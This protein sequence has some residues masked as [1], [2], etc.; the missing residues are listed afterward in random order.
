MRYCEATKKFWK[1]GYR[2]FGER[3]IRFM[4]RFK[5]TNQ[6]V[7]SETSRG[8]YDTQISDIN[9]A[10]KL[11]RDFQ[12]YDIELDKFESEP[13]IL[14]D[15]VEKMAKVMEGK[16]CCITFDG[17]KLKPG[18]TKSGGDVDL[19][20]FDNGPTLLEKKIE[21]E[22]LK[23]PIILY[24]SDIKRDDSRDIRSMSDEEKVQ[25]K[26]KLTKS[27]QQISEHI[28]DAMEMK[29][30][31]EYAKDKMIKRSEGDWRNGKYVYSFMRSFM[32]L[33]TFSENL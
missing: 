13:G 8:N 20:G 5:N 27:H 33:K 24:Q 17:K 3:F 18:L 2:L 25:L 4:S 30:K 29:R 26:E 15:M 21:L 9:F 14:H 23:Q 28:L 22:L 12:P 19:M 32:K 1:V 6:V 7:K 11:L 31:K 16:S 10:V